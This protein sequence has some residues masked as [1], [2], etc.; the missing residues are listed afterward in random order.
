MV[1]NHHNVRRSDLNMA[2]Q[3]RISN[4]ISKLTLEVLCSGVVIINSSVGIDEED[5]D[6]EI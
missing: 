1:N 3:K 5:K 6:S 2:T 4:Y